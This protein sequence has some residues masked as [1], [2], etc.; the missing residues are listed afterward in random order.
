MS[1]TEKDLNISNQSY[2]N[3]DFDSIYTELVTLAKKISY[4]YD[5]TA[6][7]ESDPFI[8][9]LKLLAFV[10]D[11][12]NYNV[13]KNI[14]ERFM[15]S[16]TQ[17][18]SMNEL[19]SRLGYNM[20]YFKAATTQVVFKYNLGV[21]GLNLSNANGDVTNIRIPRFSTLLNATNDIQYITLTDASLDI[22]GTGITSSTPVNVKQG[23]LVDFDVLGNY[24]I[25]LE[26][27][28]EHNR[29]YFPQTRVA[30][31]GVY[32]SGGILLEAYQQDDGFWECVNNLNTQ[33]YNKPCFTFRYDSEAQLPYIE[34]PEWISNIIGSGLTIKY[35]VCDGKDGNL[36]AKTLTK[37]IKSSEFDPEG[38]SDSIG[39]NFD[40]IVVTNPSAALNGQNPETIDEA[41]QGFKKTIGTFDTLV[42]CRD[43]ANAIY[44]M[45]NDATEKNLVSNV[46]VADRRTDINYG[47]NVVTYSDYGTNTLSKI[48]IDP[49]TKK[50]VISAYELCLYPLEAVDDVTATRI[51]TVTG[52]SVAYPNYN[53]TFERKADLSTIVTKLE[54]DDDLYC[55]SHDYKGA[56][57]EDPYKDEDIYLVNA[58]FILD[59]IITTV[60]KVNAV[61]E[62]EIIN[63]VKKALATNF[64]S[65]QLE[66]GYEIPYELIL[67]TIEESDARIKSVN[68]KEPDQNITAEVVSGQTTRTRGLENADDNTWYRVVVGKNILAG[69]ISLFEYDE[70][71][72][73]DFGQTEAVKYPSVMTITTE[74]NIPSL[75]IDSS[76]DTETYELQGNEAVQFICPNYITD[77]TYPVGV[78]YRYYSDVTGSSVPTINPNTTYCLRTGEKLLL[79]WETNGV[80]QR[81]LYGTGDIIRANFE[82]VDTGNDSKY[83]VSGKQIEHLIK[84]E[85]VLNSKVKAYWDVKNELNQL[86]WIPYTDSNNVIQYY[87]YILNDNEYFFYTDLASLYSFE[88]GTKLIYNYNGSDA[89]VIGPASWE[90]TRISDITTILEEGLDALVNQFKE[91]DFTENSL[92]LL[93]QTILTLTK[94]DTVRISNQTWDSGVTQFTLDF[95]NNVFTPIS[96]DDVSII[97]YKQAG[98]TEST[99]QALPVLDFVP[100]DKEDNYWI[101]AL[102]DINSAPNFKQ[103]LYGHETDLTSPQR[104][105]ITYADSTTTYET[106][107]A[108]STTDV[109]CFNFSQI[110]QFGG[111]ENISLKYTNLAL[112]ESYPEL[113]IYTYS[114]TNDLEPLANRDNEYKVIFSSPIVTFDSRSSWTTF[115]AN[116][117]LGLTDKLYIVQDSGNYYCYIYNGSAYE[118][119]YAY[120]GYENLVEYSAVLPQTGDSDHLY[121]TLED[122]TAASSDYQYLCYY[123]DSAIVAP[124]PPFS[125][126]YSGVR[127]QET[128]LVNTPIFANKQTFIMC[129]LASDIE[130]TID[131]SGTNCQIQRYMPY[132][133]ATPNNMLSKGINVYVLTYSGSGFA[134]AQ[135]MLTRQELESEVNLYI[136]QPRISN[137]YNSTLA[138]DNVGVNNDFDS[139]GEDVENFLKENYTSQMNEFYVNSHI[140]NSKAIEVSQKYPLSD[141]QSFY[142]YN[143]VVNKWVLPKID[144]D[145]SDIRI[146]RNSKKG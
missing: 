122:S 31:N 21:N 137:G 24:V 20:H 5:P 87:Y 55:I 97:S 39:F 125:P 102:L 13:D 113:Y 28:D 95:P 103:V 68:L 82:L 8:V 118:A 132:A 126:G 58:N 27:L 124:D 111:G 106:S 104:I 42:T 69:K 73:Y 36:S 110:E 2:T 41:Y 35:L 23:E 117:S 80:G 16:A 99:Y 90:I 10:G 30:Q 62:I 37:V 56:T 11:K 48:S 53:K 32:I 74:A 115:S 140:D 120:D 89:A 86:E 92:T 81:T 67:K 18:S 66:Y 45:L 85:V 127:Q 40:D 108:G 57:S 7:N 15:P 50:P 22:R 142:D 3:K 14:L 129:Y 77:M 47:C 79:T 123:Y 26:N 119:G 4:K 135:L 33:P 143:N 114:G 29:L 1:I 78:K 138:G 60:N 144:F 84:N 91:C 72:D 49:E 134:D 51:N 101:R 17:E 139:F 94:G 146:A 145:R 93:E 34:F 133:D 100:E 6:S 25:Q 46:Q 70:T 76:N 63:N 65:R 75:T 59:A 19:T 54:T 136:S 88:S 61:E 52:Q 107:F 98:E 109:K 121:V 130:V 71:F 105:T 38:I 116:T 12:I 43:Y 128:V 64:N 96:V 9:L 44:N 112:Q 131:V 141:P 83:I